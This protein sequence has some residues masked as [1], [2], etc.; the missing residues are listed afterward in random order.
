MRRISLVGSLLVVVALVSASAA[1]GRARRTLWLPFHTRVTLTG[2]TLGSHTG[3]HATGR[4]YATAQWNGGA[5]YVVA[6][7]ATDPSGHWTVRFHPSHRGDYA[8]RIL[9]PDGAVFD[10]RFVVR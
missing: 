2:Q 4:V 10:Y 6:T 7:P 1:A 5:R 9:T 3:Q 8:L